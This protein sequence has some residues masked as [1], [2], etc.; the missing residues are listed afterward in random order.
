MTASEPQENIF[1]DVVLIFV[2]EKTFIFNT[3]YRGCFLPNLLGMINVLR[4]RSSH[5]V[6]EADLIFVSLSS[7]TL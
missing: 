5:S 1:L 3:K 2:S 6:Y 4:I 7:S